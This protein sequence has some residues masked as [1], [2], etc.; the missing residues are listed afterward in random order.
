MNSENHLSPLQIEDA[1]EGISTPESRVHLERCGVCRARVARAARLEGVLRSVPRIEPAADLATRIRLAAVQA[2]PGRPSGRHSYA[3]GIAAGLLSML[4]LALVFLAGIEL[5]AG[6]A[7]NFFAFYVN[8]P[9]VIFTYPG[10]ALAALVEV[11]P[12][13]QILTTLAVVAIAFVLTSRFRSAVAMTPANSA[14][15]RA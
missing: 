7:L 2:A 9:E 5:Q 11:F 6:G 8:Q 15:H 4:A 13:A 1:A 12:L 14:N 3:L 10:D